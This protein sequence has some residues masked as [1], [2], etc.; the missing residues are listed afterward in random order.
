MSTLDNIILATAALVV[1]GTLLWMMFSKKI[2]SVPGIITV[3]VTSIL[4]GLYGFKY[5]T[6]SGADDSQI[7]VGLMVGFA[8]LAIC[9]RMIGLIN[10]L[11]R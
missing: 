11:G 7:L 10:A 6:V 4:S 5:A 9:T 8:S 3:S 2:N 1:A